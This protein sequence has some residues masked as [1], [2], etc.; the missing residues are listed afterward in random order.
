MLFGRTKMDNSLEKNENI[1][2]IDIDNLPVEKEE[3][4]LPGSEEWTSVRRTAVAV[5][6]K[7]EVV[8]TPE[9]MPEAIE[10]PQLEVLDEDVFETVNEFSDV[11]G[12]TTK[13]MQKSARKARKE[14]RK[15]LKQT[16]SDLK[17][18]ESFFLSKAWKSL[19]NIICFVLLI[20]SIGLPVCL[21]I[22]IITHFFL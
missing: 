14:A 9:I 4:D 3:S 7:A 11:E 19:W 6:P 13:E 20:I 10:E 8:P 1:E 2:K 17:G 15:E 21:L 18:D 12:R 5:E 22:Y 16:T